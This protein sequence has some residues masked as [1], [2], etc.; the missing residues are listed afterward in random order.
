MSIGIGTRCDDGGFL[1]TKSSLSK[2]TMVVCA[3]FLIG[4]TCGL[5]VTA[6]CCRSAIGGDESSRDDPTASR[7][8]YYRDVV[9]RDGWQPAGR[10]PVPEKDA[11]GNLNVYTFVYRKEALQAVYSGDGRRLAYTGALVLDPEIHPYGYGPFVVSFE[12]G[13]PCEGKS[14]ITGENQPKV[15]AAFDQ[16]GRLVKYTAM[17]IVG[18]DLRQGTYQCT[19]T[20]DGFLARRETVGDDQVNLYSGERAREFHYDEAG[21][22]V[23]EI[24]CYDNQTRARLFERDNGPPVTWRIIQAIRLPDG[25]YEVSRHAPLSGRP[26]EWVPSESLPEE[27]LEYVDELPLPPGDLN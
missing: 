21:R 18:G 6:A 15:Y 3:S 10:E 20:D 5:L 12:D 8:E 17:R 16:T 1:M 4:M 24:L 19:Y 25:T 22:T 11:L 7:V 23:L 27:F 14:V 9:L 2:P 26:G 13:I